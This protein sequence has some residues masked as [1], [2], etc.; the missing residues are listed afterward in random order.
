MF[1]TYLH[2][3]ESD[4]AVFYIGKGKGRR[5]H[6]PGGRNP[7][8]KNTVAKYGIK[9]EIVARW[10][11]EVEAFEHEI[12]LIGCFRRMGC[13]LT[14]RTDGGEGSSGCKHSEQTRQTLKTL[15]TTQWADPVCRAKYQAG[16]DKPETKLKQ[17]KAA[18]ETIRK[19]PE[20]FHLR[21]AQMHTPESQ[22][23]RTAVLSSPEARLKNSISAK[24]RF[25]KVEEREKVSISAIARWAKPGELVKMSNA[26]KNRWSNP[27]ERERKSANRAG[28]KWVT[29]G[30]N[31][32]LIK[33]DAD[34]PQGWRPGRAVI[35]TYNAPMQTEQPK[36]QPTEADW[37]AADLANNVN[38]AERKQA[39]NQKLA[40]KDQVNYLSKDVAVP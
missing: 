1:Y 3:R 12:F 9:V 28:R 16:M 17:S 27:A 7:Y 35:I 2:R 19:H 20:A 34:I 11:L 32:K 6:D 5:A 39:H 13:K 14:N 40:L 22:R 25:S 18:K 24:T 30:Q 37:I 31:S 10:E 23:N 4:N 26:A 8:W 15:V 36:P 21:V 38:K 33:P 29:D